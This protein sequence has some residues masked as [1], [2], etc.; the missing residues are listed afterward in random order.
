M[1]MKKAEILNRILEEHNN[2]EK[3]L[4]GI[5]PSRM[6]KSESDDIW[7]IK[8]TLVH[9]TAWEQVLLADYARLLRGETIHEL[10]SDDEINAL[11]EKTRA[12]GKDMPLLQ[13]L[14]EFVSSYRQ[15]IAWL[16]NLP[17]TELDRPFAYGMT[18]GEFIGEDTWKHYS[19]HLEIFLSGCTNGEIK[20]QRSL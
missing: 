11:N 17:E 19:E 10:G 20:K 7:T 8:E 13:V 6:E 12:T 4:A 3:V 9:I 2:L 18:L 15:I 16:E 1:E 5:D 14:A